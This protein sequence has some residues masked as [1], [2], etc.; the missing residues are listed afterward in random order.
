MTG[1]TSARLASRPE[2]H[3]SGEPDEAGLRA[4]VNVVILVAA[5]AALG[6]RALQLS[7][8][9]YLLGVTEYD[10][11]VYFG[12]AVRFVHGVLPYRDF[13]MVQPPG[14]VLLMTP[15]AL[16]SKVAGTAWGM[17]AARIMTALA[18]TASVVLTGL[19]VRHRGVLATAIATGIMAV[20]LSNIVD[21]H[22]VYV[23]PWLVLFLLAGLVAVFDGDQIAVSRRRLLWGGAAIGFGGAV[24]IWAIFPVVVLVAIALISAGPARLRAGAMLAVGVAVGFCA[25]VLPFAIVAARNMYQSV[26]SSQM[27]R[28]LPA[29]TGLWFRLQWMTS[30]F[31][32][33]SL[34][35]SGLIALG[36]AAVVVIVG[37]LLLGSLLARRLP[38]PLDWFA[39]VTTVIVAAAFLWN[40]QFF[41]HFPAFLA[42][43]LAMA[44]ALAIARV[45]D[46]VRASRPGPRAD[47]RWLAAI[48]AAGS[49]VAF[50]AAQLPVVT[51]LKPVVSPAAVAAARRIIPPGACVFSDQASY[52]IA[53]DRFTSTVPGC[54]E[55]VDPLEVGYALGHG[56][57]GDTGAGRYPAVV[58]V[59]RAALAKAGYAWLTLRYDSRR[60]DWTPALRSYFRRNFIAVYTDGKRD[61]LYVRRTAK[62]S[63]AR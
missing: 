35:R 58:A 27:N 47:A 12:S 4:P 63:A 16:L 10:D 40:E 25:P 41:L 26:I 52:L 56:R 45:T 60:V 30:T 17:A 5:L 59:F 19:I 24:E 11:G 34:A 53:A 61:V 9:H 8:P 14:I 21:A 50:A 1:T 48:A 57:E 39:A 44:L 38:S 18:S 23:E 2:R 43:F 62:A 37:G 20:Y 15:A 13:T 7:S 3:G 28:V 51:H 29:R 54:S 36:L 31:R 55:M 33:V 46:G 49:V 42:P 32:E 6:L 22:T